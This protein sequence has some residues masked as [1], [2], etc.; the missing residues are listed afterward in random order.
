L[1]EPNGVF[2]HQELVSIVFWQLSPVN[3]DFPSE[4]FCWASL[5]GG[6]AEICLVR[7]EDDRP[8]SVFAAPSRTAFGE[9]FPFL[10][11]ANGSCG[12]GRL[13]LPRV[14]E[15]AARRSRKTIPA[16]CFAVAEQNG[17]H[18]FYS[19]SSAKNRPASY[20]DP[21]FVSLNKQRV[22]VVQLPTAR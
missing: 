6:P 17:V 7:R 19:R 15:T 12:A 3:A 5:P 2:P 9:Q 21:A 13:D 16:A 10:L 18:H 11:L 1:P 20:P 22:L 4:V 8:C 14:V